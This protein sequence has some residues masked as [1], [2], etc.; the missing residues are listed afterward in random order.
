MEKLSKA[1]DEYARSRQ[2][3]LDYINKTLRDQRHA[4]QTFTDLEAAM[5]RYH[6][7]TGNRFTP[8]KEP[9]LSDF[10]NPSR[11]QKDTEIAL[12]IGG[13]TLVGILAYKYS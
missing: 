2:Q 13:M 1:R 10:Y 7:L 11:Q 8:L 5:Q 4:D 9:K 3:R 12:V 6:E